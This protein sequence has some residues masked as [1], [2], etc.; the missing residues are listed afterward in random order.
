IPL[1]QFALGQVYFWTTAIISFFYLIVFFFTI[2]YAYVIASSNKSELMT[3]LCITL[4]ICGCI[5]VVMACTQ[6]LNIYTP[7]LPTLELKGSRPFANFAQ[8]NHL[9]TFLFMAL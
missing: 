9:S 5:C 3:Y 1:I 8:P 4:M 7:Y 2:V 6:W